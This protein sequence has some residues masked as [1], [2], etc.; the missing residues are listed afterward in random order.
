MS[1][2]LDSFITY[3]N[4]LTLALA[5]TSIEDFNSDNMK[6]HKAFYE[7]CQKYQ[8]SIPELESIFFDHSRT[9]PL[10]SMSSQVYELRTLLGMCGE[11][12]D[13]GPF[14]KVTRMPQEIKERIKK[15]EKERLAKYENQ[16]RDMSKIFEKHL[17]V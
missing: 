8:D 3:H 2:V 17:K 10:P 12:Q 13:M 16:I 5:Y 7:I 15:R 11:L 4:V 9:P 6:W 14:F 1:N